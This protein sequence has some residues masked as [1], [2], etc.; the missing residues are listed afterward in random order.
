MCVRSENTTQSL[1]QLHRGKVEHFN[2]LEPQHCAK[3]IVM[4]EANNKTVNTK[5]KIDVL[6]L[7]MHVG[8][9]K[10]I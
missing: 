2:E 1:L 7:Q 8:K 4:A 9:T 6:T 3:L 10:C 5:I